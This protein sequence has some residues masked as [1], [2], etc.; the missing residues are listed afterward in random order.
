MLFRCTFCG[1]A[2]AARWLSSLPGSQGQGTR[3]DLL[4]WVTT[5]LTRILYWHQPFQNNTHV[6]P[7]FLDWSHREPNSTSLWLCLGHVSAV[8]HSLCWRVS[9]SA[10]GNAVIPDRV[11]RYMEARWKSPAPAASGGAAV[12]L[13]LLRVYAET[14]KVRPFL[15][16]KL[17]INCFIS[18]CGLWIQ[19]QP[20]VL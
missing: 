14:S 3:P 7:C 5:A 15:E 17:L 8:I 6:R 1:L 4:L 16:E 10:G 13:F 18:G 9:L 20:R 12:W 2:L 11:L 19:H